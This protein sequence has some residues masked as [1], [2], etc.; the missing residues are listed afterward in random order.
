LL[1]DG[2]GAG[3][4]IIISSSGDVLTNNHVIEG[5]EQIEVTLAT[6]GDVYLGTVV[7]T[8]A[9]H[10]IAVVHL[11]GASNLPVAPIGDSD[12]VQVGDAVAAIG[13]AGG[14]GGLP[15]VAPGSVT[16]LHQKVTASDLDGSNERT[17]TDLIQV[18]ANVQPGDSGG[19]LVSVDA[20]VIGVDV[21]ASVSR[22]R[23]SQA[24]AG[25]AIPITAAFKIAAQIQA[26]PSPPSTTPGTPALGSG[27]LGVQIDLNATDEGATVK[28]VQPGGPAD[29]AGIA[30][31]DVIT[32]VDGTTITV[33]SDLTDVLKAHQGGDT[34]SITWGSSDGVHT[35]S[36]TLASR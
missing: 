1:P 8:D 18:D 34:V 36:V 15:A 4:G 14:R 26:N 16:A 27:Y 2:V 20:K 13:N 5:A 3:T 30:A 22:R 17:L 21:A 32:A 24:R 25:F 31:G 7:G 23:G 6:T 11:A 33:P 19:P 9:V 28:S 10:D 35:K 29:K 12:D